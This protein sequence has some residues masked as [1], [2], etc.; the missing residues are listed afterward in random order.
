MLLSL[1]GQQINQWPAL[2]EIPIRLLFPYLTTHLETILSTDTALNGF[3]T[4]IQHNIPS[5]S[6]INSY[7]HLVDVL[8]IRDIRLIGSDCNN[9]NMLNHNI[10]DYKYHCR[11]LFNEQ[12][13]STPI[14]VT[15]VETIFNVINRMCDGNIHCLN[16]CEVDAD[17]S[18]GMS[19]RMRDIVTPYTNNH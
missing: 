12:T 5:I 4:L 14:Y 8:S 2:C 10:I 16:V 11:Q 13:P 1:L 7:G 18:T 3:Q 15:P 17:E 19:T 6:I 9:Y